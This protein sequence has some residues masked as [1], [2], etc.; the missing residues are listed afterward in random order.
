M[1]NIELNITATEDTP[2]VQY[3]IEKS[4]FRIEG[5]SLPEDVTSFYKP[6]FNWLE[7]F[8]EKQNSSSS[9]IFKLE[10]FNTASSKIILDILMKLEDIQNEGKS[11]VTIE[12]HYMNGDD[13]MQEA[14]DEYKDLVEVPFSLIEY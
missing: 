10:Y 6:V 1:D 11:N 2:S 5:R 4:E 14:G 9:F 8:A 12:W 13:D 3:L 7:N